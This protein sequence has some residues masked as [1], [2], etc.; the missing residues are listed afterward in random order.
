MVDNVDRVCKDRAMPTTRRADQPPATQLPEDAL[1]I[2]GNATPVSIPW[3]K[4]RPRYLVTVGLRDTGS[5]F[6]CVSFRVTALQEGTPVGSAVVRSLPVGALIGEAI[7]ELLRTALAGVEQLRTAP[8][9]AG[10][11]TVFDGEGNPIPDGPA[12]KA[13]RADFLRNRD[14]HLREREAKLKAMLGA[15]TGQGTGRRYPPGHLELVAEIVRDARQ[16]H[17]PATVAVAAKFRTSKSA[18]GNLIG[19]ARAQGL[20][21]NDNGGNDGRD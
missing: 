19:R 9:P 13:E 6:E 7:Q 18:A 4:V 1:R 11:I 20:L 21:D 10:D 5:E 17:K 15:A 16:E 12:L 8:P 3:P 14:A 2:E